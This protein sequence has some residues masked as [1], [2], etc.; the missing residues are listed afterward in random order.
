MVIMPLPALAGVGHIAF[1]HGVM[2]VCVCVCMC[3]YGTFVIGVSQISQLTSKLTCKFYIHI[4][5]RVS[6]GAYKFGY[7][8]AI[9]FKFG[10][11]LT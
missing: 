5:V 1:R 11:I 4:Y 8:H 2:C 10:M 3:A 9:P 6:L 7:P